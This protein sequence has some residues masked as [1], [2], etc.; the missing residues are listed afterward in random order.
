MSSKLFDLQLVFQ[1]IPA[2]LSYLPV[3]LQLV[4]CSTALSLIVGSLVAL[5][6]INRI[7]VLRQICA[8][9]VSFARGTPSIVQL[10]LIFYGMPMA[11]RAMNMYWG[12]SFSTTAPSMLCAV[13]AFTFN[14]GAYASENIR[15]ALESVDRGQ[16]EAALSIGMT[17]VQAF[18]RITLPE[19][20]VVA[21]PPLGNSFIGSIKN[22]SLAFTCAVVEMTAGAKLLASRDYRY[23]EMY[24]SLALIYWAI[25]FAV[26]RALTWAER[27]LRCDEKEVAAHDSAR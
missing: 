12:T 26:S 20:L 19:A 17:P 10:Y 9:Y 25:T 15:A 24:V 27:R 22:T 11:L 7:P 3:T 21:L 18:F 13:I 16:R 2:I 23:F 1:R 6:K 4:L 5:V 8:F 14:E